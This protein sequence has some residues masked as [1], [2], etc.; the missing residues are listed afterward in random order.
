MMSTL[1]IGSAINK[2]TLSSQVYDRLHSAILSGKIRPGTHLKMG[3]LAERL[4]VSAVP[5][6]EALRHLEAEGLVTFSPNKKIT[7]NVLSEEDLHDIYFVLMPLEELC[8]ESAFGNLNGHRYQKLQDLALKMK[9]V[10]A[11]REWVDLNWHFH[12]QI[13]EAAGSPR[14]L[15]ILKGL[16]SSIKPYFHLSLLDEKRVNQANL[17]HEEMLEAF[18]TGDIKNAK[19]ILKQ[20]LEN[21]HR[22]IER[23]LR[24]PESQ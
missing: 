3:E 21:G 22:A 5:V 8:L 15:K 6:R 7:V 4:N 23:L 16:R 9:S 17:E 13:H 11:I 2:K 18:Q 24:H 12:A 10:G 1:A 20:H 14:L 19:T